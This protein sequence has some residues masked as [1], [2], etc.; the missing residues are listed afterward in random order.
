MNKLRTNPEERD[1]KV[2]LEKFLAM[3]NQEPD[4]A[5]LVKSADGKAQTLGISFVENELDTVFFGLWSVENVTYQQ[6]INEVVC[7]VELVLTHPITGKEIRRAGFASTV[8]TQDSGAPLSSFQDTKKKNSLDLAF[9]KMKS[10][11]IKNAAQSLGKRF[12]RDLNRRQEAAYKPLINAQERVSQEAI[13][14]A[15]TELPAAKISEILVNFGDRLMPEQRQLLEAKI[16][17][18]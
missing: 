9:P 5:W 18:P 10:E 6:I 8:I 17:Q 7:T 15:L 2:R 14:Q 1:I 16:Q 12:G 4:K 13:E 11:A 3:L